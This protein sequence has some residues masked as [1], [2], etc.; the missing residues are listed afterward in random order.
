[1]SGTEQFFFLVVVPAA[2]VAVVWALA[3]IG[4]PKAQQ[5]YRPGRPYSFAPVWYVAN[6]RRGASAGG[7]AD[8]AALAGRSASRELAAADSGS[9]EARPR[10]Q[11]TGGASDRW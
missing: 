5:R 7:A 11:A 4:G 6:H 2:I 9:G 1:M 10:Q 8:Q 3:A